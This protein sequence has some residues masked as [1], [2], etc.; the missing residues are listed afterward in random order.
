MVLAPALL[1]LSIALGLRRDR[2]AGR[3]ALVGC[4][5]LMLL[6]AGIEIRR[7]QES[8]LADGV[9]ILSLFLALTQ[10]AIFVIVASVVEA[11]AEPDRDSESDAEVDVADGA[12][13]LTARAAGRHPG[14][15]RRWPRG[16]AGRPARW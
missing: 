1:A 12:G 10:I 4:S 14:A 7:Y 2:Q 15:R 16:S 3:I 6:R 11:P 8:G 13:R 5:L 9:E